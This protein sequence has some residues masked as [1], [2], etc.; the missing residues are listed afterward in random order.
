MVAGDILK[1]ALLVVE[2]F[3]VKAN[4]DIEKGEL[5]TDDGNGILAATKA[6]AATGKAMMALEDHDYSEETDH[7]ITC[8]VV[9]FVEAQKVSGSGGAK[10]GDKL[11]ISATA[12]EVTKFVKGT[13][14]AADTYATAG[15]QT[16]LDT[17]LAAVGTAIE[18][19]LDAD[20]TQKMLIGVT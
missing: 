2:K 20:A 3:T 16:A 10:K 13:A 1:E 5:V 8:V 4:E 6:L 9:G 15:T 7:D 17:N 11:T 19:S 12:G 14:P 18:A